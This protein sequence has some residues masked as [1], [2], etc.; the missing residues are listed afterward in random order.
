MFN[1]KQTKLIRPPP[2]HDVDRP[3]P[4]NLTYVYLVTAFVSLGA[5]LFGY[6]QG[7][8]GTIVA[9]ERWIQLMRPKNSWVTGAVVS[10]YDVGCFIGAMSIGYLAD[11]CGRERTLSIASVVFIVGA[12]IQ[13]ASY[14]VPTITVGRIILG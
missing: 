2:G 11:S 14:D 5:L 1:I 6:D 4:A 3:R 12:V 7:V 8:M 10:L 13:S 9:D